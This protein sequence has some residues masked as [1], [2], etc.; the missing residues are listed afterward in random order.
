M[1][2]ASKDAEREELEAALRRF[3]ASGGEIQ[4]VPITPRREQ[5]L[6]AQH[7]RVR[8]G[9]SR[10]R[11]ASQAR[12]TRQPTALPPHRP[13]H[14]CQVSS[15]L[16]AIPA[17]RRSPAPSPPLPTTGRGGLAAAKRNSSPPPLSR[18]GNRPGYRT[19]PRILSSTFSRPRSVPVGLTLRPSS[20]FRDAR[21]LLLRRSND[22]A[23]EVVGYGFILPRLLAAYAGLCAPPS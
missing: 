18:T 10:S 8:P 6:R 19:P 7:A 3:Q 12:R 20:P 1:T 14:Q 4:E 11:E 13:R 9:S 15:L 21:P 23:S 5:Y 16:S 17:N 2:S 22:L